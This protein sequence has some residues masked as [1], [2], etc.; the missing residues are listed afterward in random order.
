M[1]T[2]FVFCELFKE[3]SNPIGRWRKR[4]APVKRPVA[5]GPQATFKETRT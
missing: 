2:Y 4:V 5:N 3:G 1:A